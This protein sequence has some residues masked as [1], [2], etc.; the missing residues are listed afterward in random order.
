MSYMNCDLTSV[1]DNCIFCGKNCL[2][3][4]VGICVVS[5]VFVS[6]AVIKDCVFCME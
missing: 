6:D 2:N 3:V 5:S 4:F 1:M